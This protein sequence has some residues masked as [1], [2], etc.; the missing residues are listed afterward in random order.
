MSA[1]CGRIVLDAEIGDSIRL[2]RGTQ[3]LAKGR[4]GEMTDKPKVKYTKEQMAFF[5]IQ[6]QA[7]FERNSFVTKARLNLK[8]STL[9]ALAVFYSYILDKSHTQNLRDHIT[10]IKY[11]PVAM[12]IFAVL[13]SLSFEHGAKKRAL[14]MAEIE[15]DTGCKGYYI[16]SHADTSKTWLSFEKVSKCIWLALLCCTFFCAAFLI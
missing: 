7:C 1:F 12:C 11:I 2:T 15:N 5:A 3:L 10:I 4:R 16:L 13:I 9:A 14:V 8:L 6:Y